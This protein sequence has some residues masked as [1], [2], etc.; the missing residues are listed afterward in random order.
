MYQF[1][2][3]F[4]LGAYADNRYDLE[5][6]VDTVEFAIKRFLKGAEKQIAAIQKDKESVTNEEGTGDADPSTGA[7]ND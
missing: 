7:K 5:P 2:F 6:Y 4:C 3:G 1:C